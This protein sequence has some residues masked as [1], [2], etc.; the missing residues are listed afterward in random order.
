MRKILVVATLALLSIT[1]LSA[2]KK[3]AFEGTVTYSISFEGSGLPQEALSMLN[4]AE[5]VSYIKGDKRR[6]DMNM[7]IQST[8]SIIDEKTKDVVTLMDIMGQKYLI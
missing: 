7:A 3:A 6:T 4:G 5:A 2:Q 1:T 8:T